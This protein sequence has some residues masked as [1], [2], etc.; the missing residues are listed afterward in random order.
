MP[1][2]P[3]EDFW[4]FLRRNIAF[5][6]IYL[7]V[8]FV[9][10]LFVFTSD[11]DFLTQGSGTERANLLVSIAILLIMVSPPFFSWY[12]EPKLD[13]VAFVR[14]PAPP[15]EAGDHERYQ[16]LWVV[17]NR[18]RT[19]ARNVRGRIRIIS[20]FRPMGADSDTE[21]LFVDGEDIKPIWHKQGPFAT[22][23][24]W[25]TG[26]KTFG[27]T[28]QSKRV[29]EDK[30]VERRMQ[31]VKFDIFPVEGWEGRMDVIAVLSFEGDNLRESD[32]R[33]R[34]YEIRVGGEKPPF[35]APSDEAVSFV[36]GEIGA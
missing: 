14:P 27:V 35:L 9:V 30:V 20:H 13:I 11:L 26:Q 31:E 19:T 5:L 23:L 36:F 2:N 1:A 28:Y 24:S 33:V 4:T 8:A 12:R 34:R 21:F 3:F 18:G 22:Y 29:H 10:V 7:I 25:G 15:I 32:K 6:I 17:R 16:I